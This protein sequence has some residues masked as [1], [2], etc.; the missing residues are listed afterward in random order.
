MSSFQT[1]PMST[2]VLL[3]DVKKTYA[4]DKILNIFRCTIAETRN[5]SVYT[6]GFQLQ[7]KFPKNSS[8]KRPQ[9]H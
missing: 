1:H 5:K 8:P 6:T 3:V 4:D 9:L 2:I 7:V